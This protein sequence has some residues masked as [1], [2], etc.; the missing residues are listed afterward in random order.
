MF[1][2]Y[3]FRMEVTEIVEDIE[4]IKIECELLSKKCFIKDLLLL[5]KIS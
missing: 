1:L 3:F 5:G 2:Y 4:S